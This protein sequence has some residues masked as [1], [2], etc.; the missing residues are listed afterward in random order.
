MD[1]SIFGSYWII[2]L[3]ALACM[4]VSWCLKLT[5]SKYSKVLNSSMTSGKNMAEMI[6]RYNGITDV[7]IQNI[8]GDLTDHFDPRNKTVGLSSEVYAGYSIA[9]VAIAAHECGHVM[10]HEKGYAPLA[11]RSMLLPVANI[12]SKLSMPLIFLGL[13]VNT[14][15][16]DTLIQFG[17]IAFGLAVLF[18]VVTL[19]VEFDASARALKSLRSMNVLSA[20]EM[21]GA[22][23]VLTAAAMTYVASTAYA[24]LNLLRLIAIFGGGRRRD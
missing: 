24:L 4:L 22:R 20:S 19:P 11:F 1:L 3:A 21:P 10:Q 18:Q 7:S 6:L 5:Y 17:L 13:L 16:S 9:S 14:G 23:S 2:I 15:I 12:G 8:S